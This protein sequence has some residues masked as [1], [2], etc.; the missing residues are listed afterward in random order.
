MAYEPLERR[1]AGTP[2]ALPAQLRAGLENMSGVDLSGV[3][4]HHGSDR[5]AAVGALAYT[6]GSNIYLGHGQDHHLAHEGWHAV[7]QAQGR[8]SATGTVQGVGLNDSHAL[9]SEA[10]AKGAEASALGHTLQRL[11]DEEEKLGAK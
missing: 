3:R 5:P 7:Q 1:S 2:A 8:V 9:E 10:D 11:T 6:Q 4:V